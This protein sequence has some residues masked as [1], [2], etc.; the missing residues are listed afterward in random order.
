MKT[1][2][3]RRGDRWCFSV[4]ER[5][6][7]DVS[8]SDLPMLGGKTIRCIRCG[9][10]GAQMHH[11][12]P[13]SIAGPKIANDWPISLLCSDCHMEWHRLVTPEL[14]KQIQAHQEVVK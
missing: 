3:T 1:T 13:K 12:V 14:Y 4:G 2:M 7:L 5:L 8:A 6:G 9:R 11:W 10:D